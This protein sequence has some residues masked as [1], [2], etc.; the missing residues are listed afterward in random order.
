VHNSGNIVDNINLSFVPD[1]WPDITIDTPVL[2]DVAP[3]EWRQ[4]KLNVHVPENAEGYTYKGIT[5]V[6]ESQFCGAHDDDNAQAYVIGVHE[7]DVTIS[8]SAREGLL[9]ENLSYD[10]VVK[11]TGNAPDNYILDLT[12]T[13]GWPYGWDPVENLA[14]ENLR[15]TQD[16]Q[17][18]ENEPTTNYGDKYNMYVGVEY[19]NTRDRSYLKFDL[20]SVPA[21]SMIIG[22][23]LSLRT[24][25]GPSHPPDYTDDNMWIQAMSVSDDSWTEFGITWSNAPAPG[26]ML[27]NVYV[28]SDSWAPEYSRWYWDVTSFVKSEFAGDKV[29]SFCMMS[30]DEEDRPEYNKV[31]FYQKDG[32]SDPYWPWLEVIWAPKQTVEIAP[33]DNWTSLIWVEI[34]GPRCTTDTLTVTATSVADP[35]VSDSDNCTAHS[36]MC[37]VEVIIENKLLDGAPGEWLEYTIS[38]HNSGDIVD[39]INLSFVPDGWP[40]INI[41]T[42]VLIDVAP[43]EWRQA[44]LNV[45]VPENAARSSSRTSSWRGHRVSGSST[46]SACTTR[47]T[48]R[49]TSSSASCRTDGQTST[50]TLQCSSTSHHASGGRPS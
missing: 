45:H 10:V 50:S 43:C 24:R 28:I 41:D 27:D 37:G 42:P 12:D 22:A 16:A 44:K 21:E 25:Y 13:L 11:N 4:A 47:A 6:A 5:V 15:P 23:T 46:P 49:T 31:W 17:V 1:G 38:V 14:V 8:P 29:A 30:Q 39:N 7:V 35:M 33:R 20:A 34:S 18:L 3:C 19:T 32:Y 40:D 2:I 36:I 9:D 48:S 26:A